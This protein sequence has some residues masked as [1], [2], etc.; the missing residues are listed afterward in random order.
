MNVEWEK[1][2]VL[3]VGQGVEAK[4]ECDAGGSVSEQKA[5][6]SPPL[7]SST[8]TGQRESTQ[9]LMRQEGR[10]S[11]GLGSEQGSLTL[12]DRSTPRNGSV[13][14]EVTHLPH[15]AFTKHAPQPIS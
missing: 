5:R 15:Y 3:S 2:D 7:P 1:W 4:D 13:T 10:T 6:A 11:F 8:R 12:L 9:V 14:H